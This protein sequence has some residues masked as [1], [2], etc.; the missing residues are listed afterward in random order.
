MLGRGWLWLPP[1]CLEQAQLSSVSI[2]G[3]PASTIASG[4]QVAPV[5]VPGVQCGQGWEL[6]ARG[7][8]RGQRGA[9]WGAGACDAPVAV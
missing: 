9:A 5:R 3:A 1:P 4:T 7:Q 2:W 6:P 8:G